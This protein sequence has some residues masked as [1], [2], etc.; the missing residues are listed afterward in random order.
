MLAGAMQRLF[1]ANKIRV[2]NYGK[3]SWQSAKIV[4]CS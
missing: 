2:E 3:P 1:E 4:L